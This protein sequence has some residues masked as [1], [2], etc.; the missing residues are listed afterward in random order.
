MEADV[1]NKSGNALQCVSHKIPHK[2]GHP[3]LI[4]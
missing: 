1:Q 3:T 2:L 4:Y